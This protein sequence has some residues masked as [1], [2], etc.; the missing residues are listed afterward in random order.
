MPFENLRF[1][2]PSGKIE[3]GSERFSKLGLPYAPVPHADKSPTAGKLRVLS[4]ASAWLLNSSYNND[5]RI[6]DRLKRPTVAL[7]PEEAARRG[8]SEEA[9]SNL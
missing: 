9:P 4:P 2:T 7:H 6:A 5:A 3:I 1:P 8:L